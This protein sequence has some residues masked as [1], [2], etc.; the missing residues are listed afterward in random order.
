MQEKGEIAAWVIPLVG[1]PFDLEDVPLWLAGQTVHVVERT[2]A[3]QLV[4]PVSVVGANYQPVRAFAENELSLINGIGR[5]VGQGFRPV[6]LSDRL[7]GID[8]DGTVVHTVV[9]LGAAETREKA[10]SVRAVVGGKLQRDP[11]E[12][13]ASPLLRAASLSP[14]A[15]DALSIVG[16]AALTWSELYLLF[17]LVEA[18]VGGEMFDR[19]WISAADADLLTHTANSYTA[20]RSHGRHGKERGEPPGQPMQLDVA[21]K[22]VRGLVLS[23][24]RHI[25]SSTDVQG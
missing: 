23:W 12:A 9:A 15:H 21:T 13:A 1:H 11:R 5:L 25:G 14:R 22:L 17:E 18:D 24:L 10:G 4:I 3:Y 6:S 19:G 2:G 20:L 8:A 7:F 16:R